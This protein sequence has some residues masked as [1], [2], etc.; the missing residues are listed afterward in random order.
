[1]G[2]GKKILAA[3]LTAGVVL[4]GCAKPPQTPDP[5]QSTGK[6]REEIQTMLFTFLD[7]QG[8]Q[9][10]SGTFRNG[11]R[12]S[13]V[14]LVIA[15]G[16]REKMTALQLNPDTVVS[17]T[18][19]GS[20]EKLET[21][22]GLV[23]SYGSGGSDS[24]QS[25][26][27]AVSQLLGGIPIDH[28]MTFTADALAAVTDL[29]GGVTVTTGDGGEAVTLKGEDTVTFF[30]FREEVDI[31]NEDRMERQRQYIGELL[32][33]FL[34]NAGQEEFLTK[35]TFQA[36]E[37]MSTNLTLSQ[38]AGMLELLGTYDLEKT[39]VTLP[40]TAEQVDGEYRFRV[41]PEEASKIAGELFL[42]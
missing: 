32:P 7:D 1:M 29:L 5:T 20:G 39:P 18:P 14:L 34:E 9:V 11:N 42:P 33:R 15:D 30:Q 27:K 2:K 35:L 12:A 6:I 16:V 3:A 22:L 28:Y 10:E 24:C 26:M 41:D 13:L 19:P 38:M 25:G 8:F 21:S 40:G 37:G 31:T 17:I 4:A 36:G 23:Y